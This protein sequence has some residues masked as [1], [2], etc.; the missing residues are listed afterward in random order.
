MIFGQVC[1]PAGPRRRFSRQTGGP[2][3]RTASPKSRR[4][5]AQ[6]PPAGRGGGAIPAGSAVL[7]RAGALCGGRLRRGGARRFRRWRSPLWQAGLSPGWRRTPAWRSRTMSACGGRGGL[8][9]GALRRGGQSGS[10]LW[11][12][13]AWRA[14]RRSSAVAADSGV[15]GMPAVS[16]VA[17]V[18]GVAGAADSGRGTFGCGR[19]RGG[20]QGC[21]GGGGTFRCGA[22][23]VWRRPG[24]SR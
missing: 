3:G 11:L 2:T 21:L 24:R 14:S 8:A 20:G 4:C 1:G 10:R 12:S 5:P 15:A 16:A 13:P 23:G 19:F 9:C 17:P 18:S 22:F 7:R 6:A